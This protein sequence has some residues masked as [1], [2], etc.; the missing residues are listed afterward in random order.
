MESN[1]YRNSMVLNGTFIDDTRILA[2]ISKSM[3]SIADSLQL[4]HRDLQEL[5]SLND[6][7][8]LNIPYED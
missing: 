4:I 8:P 5:N 6:H 2:D 1:A 7:E 3:A